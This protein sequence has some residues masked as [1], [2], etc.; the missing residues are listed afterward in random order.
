MSQIYK[1]VTSGSLPPDVPTSFIT[2]ENSPAVPI[3]NE[4]NVLGGQSDEDNDNGIRTDGSSGSNTLTIQ[5]TNRIQ[6]G[7]TTND[8]TPTTA[9]SFTMVDV[10]SYIFE[11]KA[12]AY[13][14]TDGLS[15]GYSLF[16]CA[17][18]DGADSFL[19]GTPDKIVNEEGG[20][21]LCDFN[22]IVGGV[23]SG[24]VSFQVTGLAGKE[25]SWCTVGLYCI[26]MG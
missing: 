22:M 1:R 9:S 10:G 16:G 25:I 11:M 7:I 4:L 13:N 2:D 5:L 20:M 8:A 15:A 3:N 14:I 21:A 24:L 23:G 19:V 26:A 6:G 12:S 17:R 18:F